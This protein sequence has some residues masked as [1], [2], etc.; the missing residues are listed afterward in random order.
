M[1]QPIRRYRHDQVWGVNWQV[2]HPV[3]AVLGFILT[4]MYRN[5]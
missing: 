4:E 3:N 2:W 1:W 5:A